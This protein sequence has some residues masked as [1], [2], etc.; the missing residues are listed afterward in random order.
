MVSGRSVYTELKNKIG[1]LE[2]DYDK[3]G[4]KVDGCEQQITSLMNEKE[5]CYGQLAE[6]YLPALDVGSIRST[7]KIV[8]ADV[9]RIF[10]Q[11]QKRRA[12]LKEI[13][14]TSASAK[15]SLEDKLGEVTDELN[16]KVAE[17]D[18][19]VK[20]VNS[21]LKENEKY[22]TLKSKAN[23]TNKQLTEFHRR[24]KDMKEDTAEKLPS[25]EDNKLFK[26]LISRQYGTPD[27]TRRGLIASLDGWV[28]KVINF[29]ENKQ[30]Y[31][32]LKAV[33]K[34]VDEETKKRQ[35]ELEKLVKGMQS[36]E[37]EYATR[38]GL[39]KTNSEGKSFGI[40]R[41]KLLGQIEEKDTEYKR[42][43]SELQESESTKDSHYITAISNLKAYLKGPR[44]Q[45]LKK[46]ALETTSRKDDNLVERIEEI[47][48]S[49]REFKDKSKN[50]KKEQA[51]TET[52]VDELNEIKQ[53]FNRNDYESGS[54]YFS[55]GFDINAYLMGY[56]S[57]QYSQSQ[58]WGHIHNHHHFRES[59]SYD[60]SSNI[61]SSLNSLSHQSSTSHSSGIGIGGGGFS[62]GG[63]FGG[64]GFSSGKG[65]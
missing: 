41:D 10:E 27:Y 33:P 39:T 62:S 61:S 14:S 59:E 24:A 18:K 8:Q 32:L 65:F 9:K 54:S 46:K 26:Y 12:E 21:E 6:F 23:A 11:K 35:T 44:V 51:D 38:I 40:Y 5:V 43:A 42:A 56:L 36:I 60:S 63:G 29:S 57:G 17:R 31:E 37:E 64:G 13:M 19:L 48:T 45:E 15:G 50:L 53:K 1:A 34:L 20:K 58:L 25:F 55:S 49:I 22:D 16:K 7:L 28:A 4:K 47:D 52:K 3:I 30:S 2:I